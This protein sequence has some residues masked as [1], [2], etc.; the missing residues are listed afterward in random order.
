MTTVSILCKFRK[1]SEDI[2][3]DLTYLQDGNRVTDV[4]NTFMVTTG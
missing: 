4:E 2:S 1:E 3:D